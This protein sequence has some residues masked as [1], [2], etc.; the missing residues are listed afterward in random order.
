MAGAGSNSDHKLKIFP[1]SP[2][3]QREI[4]HKEG[5]LSTSKLN[6]IFLLFSARRRS[7]WRG[8][9]RNRRAHKKK[10]AARLVDRGNQSSLSHS[11]SI[12][13]YN[14]YLRTTV[15]GPQIGSAKRKSANL[16]TNKV[17]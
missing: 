6:R 12:K 4:P 15:G 11:R 17:C 2:R 16:R 5:F 10:L 7:G 1:P 3:G 8:G 13:P 9:G 14:G